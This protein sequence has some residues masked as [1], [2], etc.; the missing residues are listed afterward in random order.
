[1]TI[2]KLLAAAV[3]QIPAAQFLGEN[4]VLLE[5]NR[6]DTPWRRILP[7]WWHHSDLY[8]K[9]D[10]WPTAWKGAG[11]EPIEMYHTKYVFGVKHGWKL[12]SI[13]R[14]VRNDY[15]RTG[16]RGIVCDGCIA[17]HR[18][19]NAQNIREHLREWYRGAAAEIR[20]GNF[21]RVGLPT[22]DAQLSTIDEHLEKEVIWCSFDYACAYCCLEGGAVTI[23]H[24]VPTSRGGHDVAE[25]I[26]PCCPSCNSSKC[27]KSASEFVSRSSRVFPPC[28]PRIIEIEATYR[29]IYDSLTRADCL[30]IKRPV[31]EAMR[32]RRVGEVYSYQPIASDSRSYPQLKPGE[33]LTIVNVDVMR[34]YSCTAKTLSNDLVT[35]SWASVSKRVSQ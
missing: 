25:N 14:H 19:P 13:C 9:F 23:D 20:L 22:R 18:R 10:A 15:R 21:E 3:G 35:V 28:I 33:L 5:L 4:S 11:F 8:A 24:V 29:S 2:E 12:C 27:A 34:A 30:A 31:V 32:P 16:N 17:S 1:L 6:L 26:V 7:R